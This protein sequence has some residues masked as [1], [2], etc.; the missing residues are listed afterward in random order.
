M[1]K[2]KPIY[3]DIQIRIGNFEGIPIYETITAEEQK[4][5][6]SSGYGTVKDL[7]DLNTTSYRDWQT[8]C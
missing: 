3:E 8:D 4:D 2:K 5:F 6:V 7:I 1:T